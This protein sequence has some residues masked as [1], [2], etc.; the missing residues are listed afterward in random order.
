MSYYLSKGH[1]LE[2]LL[3]L[4]ELEKMFFVESMNFENE[5]MVRFEESKLKSIFG[6]GGK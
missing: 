2:Y 5:K 3:N 6:E 1:S 4:N